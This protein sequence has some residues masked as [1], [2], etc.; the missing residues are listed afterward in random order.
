[1]RI[2]A[3]IFLLMPPSVFSQSN[4]FDFH[5]PENIKKFAD[6]LFCENDYLRAVEEYESIKNVLLNDTIDFKI[7]LCYSELGM[8]QMSNLSKV[9]FSNSLFKKD[10]VCLSLK[11]RFKESPESFYLLFEI[12]TYFFSLEDS[13]TLNYFQKLSG[14]SYLLGTH[15]ILP[16]E[17]IINPFESSDKKIISDYYDWKTDPPYKSPALAGILSAVIPGSGKMYVGE[18]GDGITALLVTGLFA[19]LAYDNF[20]ADHTTR[21]WIFTGLGAFFYAGNIYG[22]VASAQIFNARI[23][24]EFNDGLNLFIEQRNYFLPEYDFCK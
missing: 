20:Q 19:F 9:P 17:K 10:A 4:S 24:F 21:A 22:S 7:M 1:M 13:S 2:F 18:W 15:E 16:K 6:H 14:V 3:V 8:Y 12:S 11:N 5:S 23:D